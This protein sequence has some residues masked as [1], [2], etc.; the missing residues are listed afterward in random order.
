MFIDAKQRMKKLFSLRVILLVVMLS[1]LLM[2]LASLFFFRFYENVLVQK[3]ETELI[4]QSAVLSS[5]YREIIGENQRAERGFYYPIEPQLDLSKQKIL[6]PRPDARFYPSYAENE[7]YEVA[8]QA[9]HNMLSI[10]VNT[11]YT[12]L[13][14]MHILDKEG[15]VVAGQSEVNM[16]M[17]HIYEV[18][19]A[20]EGNYAS[21]IRQRILDEPPPS[22]ASIS[23]GTGIRV[24]VAFPI[25]NQDEVVGVVYTSRTPQNILIHLYSIKEKVIFLGLLLLGLTGIIVLFI[26]SRLSRPIRELLP[27][28]GLWNYCKN[29]AMICQRVNEI[30]L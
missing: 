26:S 3:T 27:C 21:V 11:Q 19:Q 29:M 25:I 6:P 18:K 20:L 23:R 5:V 1:V 13:A 16:S 30:V 17:S 7:N 15:V 8:A 24:F 22:I 10:L 12:T 9:R 2:P 4:T 14:G 28:R